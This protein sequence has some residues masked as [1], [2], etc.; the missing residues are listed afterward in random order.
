MLYLAAFDPRVKAAVSS[1][2]GIGTTFSNWDAPWYLGTKQ[3]GREHHE[4]L[5]LAAPRA[6]LLI[7]GNS[8]DGTKSWPFVAAGMEV[9]RLFAQTTRIG[10]YNHGQGHKV[11]P[12]AEQRVYEWLATYL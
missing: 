1:E 6:F 7:G 2:G 12:L 3:F 10:L 11:P 8:A 9:H 5:G 4:L